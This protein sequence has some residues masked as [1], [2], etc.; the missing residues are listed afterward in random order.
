[1]SRII[2]PVVGVTR[3]EWSVDGRL[4][5]RTFPSGSTETWQYD[6]EG[7]PT[8]LTDRTGQVTRLEY[9]PFD[10]PTV[11][12]AP[13]GT[14][15][16]FSYD[17][18]LRLTAV[19]DP[20]GDVWHYRFDRAGRLISEIDFNGRVLRYSYDAA[21]RLSRRVNGAGQA[22]DYTRDASGNIVEARSGDQ[23]IRFGHDAAG[24]LVRAVNADADLTL[25]R[26]PMGRI[27]TETCGGRTL[28]SAYDAAGRRVNRRTPSGSESVW[29]H[30]QAGRAVALRAGGQDIRF[31]FDH[32]GREV[33]RHL[34]TAAVMEQQWDPDHLL[35][36]QTLSDT[37]VGGPRT[38]QHRVYAYR[39]DGRLIRVRDGAGERH[40]DLDRT[41][42]VTA[43]RAENWSERYAYDA[44]GNVTEAFWPGSME[45]DL[46]G[47]RAYAGT[48]L[49]RAGRVHFDHDGQGRVVARRYQTVSG[50]RRVWYYTWDA[51]DRMV[52]VLAPDGRRWHY[53]YD[54]L[55]RRVVKERLP[56][57]GHEYAERTVF[58]WDGPR[59]AE[60]VRLGDGSDGA[61]T[62][63][64][65]QPG[66]FAPLTQTE[67][68]SL[69]DRPQEW[70]D[71]RFY[72]VVTDRIGSPAELVDPAGRVENLAP[73]TLWGLGHTG[74][75]DGAD[76]P[77]RF[78]GQYHD[79]ETGLSYNY[80]RYYDPATGRYD[81]PDPLGF[82]PQP[83][84]YAYAANPNEGIDPLGLAVY[85]PGRTAERGFDQYRVGRLPRIGQV[86]LDFHVGHRML[87][88]QIGRAGVMLPGHPPNPDFP[89]AIGMTWCPGPA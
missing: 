62:S 27:L 23:V 7:N 68:L 14:R 83:N 76:C 81:T 75:P 49:R 57:D 52:G 45:S 71:Q 36:A 61:V 80:F 85:E 37:A 29:R 87:A 40:F 6:A 54:A 32:A 11:R 17:S 51:F 73:G 65:Y 84:P 33:R 38:L 53:R 69:P 88:D 41:G 77:L 48:L 47:D 12:T 64:N 28:T 70:Y 72:A 3:L 5:S 46:L 79:P 9:G 30:D 63:W 24:R 82:A 4:L 13:D 8:A 21:G 89:A 20:A 2:D 34:G 25:T 39:P 31:V 16:S 10:V 19:T 58:T 55:G 22:V 78:P 50:Q 59:L 67:R 18:E 35:V 86:E 15:L 1:V 74:E 26:D 42:R 44:A 60:Q 43:V 66:G 56:V